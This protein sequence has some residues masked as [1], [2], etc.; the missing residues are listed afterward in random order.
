MSYFQFQ[1]LKYQHEKTFPS[2]EQAPMTANAP[3]SKR[4]SL[5]LLAYNQE[6]IVKKAAESCLT[7]DCEP[8]EIIFSDDASSDNTFAVLQ[9]L[10]AEYSGPHHVRA[11]RN[12][13]NLGIGGHYNRLVEECTGELIVTAAGDDISLPH[14]VRRMAEAWDA[15]G[16]KADLISSH[17]TEMKENGTLGAIVPTDDLA[18]TTL[19]TWTVKRPN[20]VGATHAFTRRMMLHFGPFIQGLWYEDQV[21]LLRSLMLGGAMTIPEPLI[22]YSRG[23]TSSPK[24]V[25]GNNMLAWTHA[26]FHRI[27]AENKQLIQDAYLAG[28]G[29]CIEKAVTYYFKRENYLHAMLTATSFSERYRACMAEPE[30]PL[31][32]RLRKCVYFTFPNVWA[33]IKRNRLIVREALKRKS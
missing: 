6:S 5:I 23:G 1:A 9:S 12:E 32:W 13:K 27:V 31:L 33:A 10:A 14:R 19:A 24:T 18:A 8:L 20:I 16:Q 7:Q 15:N 21:M 22:L 4:I 25:T 26:H 3:G 17:F 28:H 30:L 2:D 29:E 11:R